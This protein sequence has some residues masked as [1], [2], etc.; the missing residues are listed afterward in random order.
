MDHHCPWVNSCVGI[1]N[2]KYFLLFVF[3]TCLSCLYSMSLV[4]SRFF[5]CMRTHGRHVHCLDQPTHLLNI[6]GL[7][8]ESLLFG[9]FTCCMICDQ[10]DVVMSNMTH[11]DRLKGE[12]IA[13]VDRVPG[14]MEVFGAGR[15]GARAHF[16]MDWLSPFGEVMFPPSVREQILGYCRP[17]CNKNSE[18][19]VVVDVELSAPLK[20]PSSRGGMVKSVTEI[21]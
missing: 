13:A 8:V 17:C 21:V 12:V 18:R 10:W 14:V 2:H 16:R 20:S 15:R 3:Y 6:L 19:E 9:L 7:M 11:I 5:I 1:G 4:V